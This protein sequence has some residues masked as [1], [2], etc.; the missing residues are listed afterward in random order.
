MDILGIPA[1]FNFS[2]FY[3]NVFFSFIKVFL[4]FW[5][6]L[7]NWW[8]SSYFP[9][10]LYNISNEFK[11]IIF[12]SSYF[13]M[14]LVSSKIYLAVLVTFLLFVWDSC[15]F[16]P[17]MALLRISS[18]PLNFAEISFSRASSWSNDIYFSL[19]CAYYIYFVSLIFWSGWCKTFST[20][21]A[22]L[23]SSRI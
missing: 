9:K 21:D 11:F 17:F 3:K 13:L 2:L 16:M 1:N 8:F 10:S 20:H 5:I 14:L 6:N 15:K 18:I 19:C 23:S 7:L 4:K 12:S 22:K